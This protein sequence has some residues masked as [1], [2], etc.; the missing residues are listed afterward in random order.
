[1]APNSCYTDLNNVGKLYH[2]IL[3]YDLWHPV[4]F[5]DKGTLRPCTSVVAFLL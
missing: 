5:L 2:K 4:P 3:E 1:M